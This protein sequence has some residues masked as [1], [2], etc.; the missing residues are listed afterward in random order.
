MRVLIACEESQE[1]CKAFRELGHEAYSCDI[2]ECSGGHPEWHIKDDVLNHLNERWDLMIAHPPCTYLSRGGTRWLFPKGKLNEER[3]KKG[4]QAK[5]FFMKL[6]NAKIPM[7]AV[8]N[9]VPHKVFNMPQE[10]QRIQPYEFG[11][12]HQKTTLL[13]LKSLPEL[14]PTKMVKPEYYICS[15][16]WRH[17][18]FTAN[19]KAKQKSKTFKGIA[20]AMAVQWGAVGGFTLASPTFP[21]EKA[22]NR[23]LQ[24]TPSASPKEA[25]LPSVNS[26]IM[27]RC[28]NFIFR[29]N[30]G[31]NK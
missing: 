6:L 5:E 11:H 4:L 19:W 7:I 25:T 22:I 3:F 29:L 28:P 31:S 13:W 30:A 20:Q 8:E 21:T 17:S 14:K 24:V 26:D 27:W 9:P 2:L 1:V 10:S 16:G 18:K 15:K 12:P 23:N